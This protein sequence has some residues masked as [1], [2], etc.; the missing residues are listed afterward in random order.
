MSI[1]DKIK[2]EC[3]ISYG[4]QQVKFDPGMS[5]KKV[6][7]INKQQDEHYKKYMFFKNLEKELAK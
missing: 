4:L 1:Q 3:K 5:Y 2:Q 7:E 6:K